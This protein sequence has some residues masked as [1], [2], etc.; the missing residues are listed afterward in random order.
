MPEYPVSFVE[1]PDVGDRR[2]ASAEVRVRGYTLEMAGVARSGCTELRMVAF[3]SGAGLHVQV[4]PSNTLDSC[5]SRR[6]EARFTLPPEPTRLLLTN[7]FLFPVELFEGLVQPSE[8][9]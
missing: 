8:E 6:F 2:P 5:G 9:G 3:R 4:E 1:G 7:G